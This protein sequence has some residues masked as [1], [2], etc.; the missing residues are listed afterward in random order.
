MDIVQVLTEATTVLNEEIKVQFV[1][2]GHH[3]SGAWED[4]I[5]TE[6][7]GDVAIGTALYY[8]SIVNAGT[9]ASRIPYG[10][11]SSGATTSKY[12]QGLYGYFQ[13]RGLTDKDALRAAFA[14]AKVQKKEGMSTI[15]SRSYSETGIR[16][17][18]MD[19]IDHSGMGQIINN[20]MYEIISNFAKVGQDINVDL[21]VYL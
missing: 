5:A 16:Q 20:G 1:R 17:R 19:A 14:T 3:L 21:Q 4:S 12:I 10:G 8:G 13:A 15:V 2:Q 9:P 11:Q 18:F 7:K 6:I